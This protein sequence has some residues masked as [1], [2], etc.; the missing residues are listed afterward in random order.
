[1]TGPGSDGQTDRANGASGSGRLSADPLAAHRSASDERLLEGFLGGDEAMFNELIQRHERPLYAFICR[2]VG[3]PGDAAD[4]F[5]ETFTRVV[6]H[7]GSFRGASR[8]RTWLYA[9][10]ANLCRSHLRKARRARDSARVDPT[11]HPDPSAGPG[12]L[13]ASREIGER[14]ALA[15]QRLP[16][17]Q[18]EVVVLRVYDDMSYREIAE[19]VERPLGTVKS[20]MRLALGKLRSDLRAIAQLDTT[21]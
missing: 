10:A 17:E 16:G 9:I 7:G 1:M 21:E 12:N 15:V 6:R 3:D 4:L 5:Q 8:F 2:F 14:V 20:Q 18:R 11:L 19:V 13:V